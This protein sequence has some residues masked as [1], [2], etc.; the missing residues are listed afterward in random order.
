MLYTSDIIRKLMID[1]GVTVTQLAS[2]MELLQPTLSRKL[3]NK[4][5]D[6]KLSMLLDIIKTLDCTLKIDIIDSESNKVLYT[7]KEDK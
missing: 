1:K 5:E 2:K 3:Q 6:Y 7:I 4:N